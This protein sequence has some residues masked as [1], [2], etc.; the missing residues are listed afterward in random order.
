[1]GYLLAGVFMF[2]IVAILLLRKKK[3]SDSACIAMF[4]L[5]FFGAAFLISG[6]EA[7]D[8]IFLGVDAPTTEQR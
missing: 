3:N 5:V 1:M 6:D 7:L 4:F 8:K 2:V